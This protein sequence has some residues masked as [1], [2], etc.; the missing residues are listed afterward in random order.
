MLSALL[1]SIVTV[2]LG[3]KF[4][5]FT[6]ADAKTWVVPANNISIAMCL[7]QPSGIKGKLL[8]SLF[9]LLHNIPDHKD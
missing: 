7:Y 9:P 5:R 4:Y 2:G 3:D 1:N 8:K 6:N